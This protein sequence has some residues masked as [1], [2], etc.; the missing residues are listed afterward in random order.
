MNQHMRV[1]YLSHCRV[2]FR[3]VWANEQIRRVIRWSHTQNMDVDEDLESSPAGYVSKCVLRRLCEYVISSKISCAGKLM[4]FPL[5]PPIIAH[6]VV[7]S[8]TRGLKFGLS[9][10]IYSYFA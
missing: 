1:L 6:S 7:P 10:H 9:L 4:T 8:G 3:R 5:K 2:M